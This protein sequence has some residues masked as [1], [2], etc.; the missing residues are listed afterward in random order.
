MKCYTVGLNADYILHFGHCSNA[1]LGKW[2]IEPF[3][4]LAIFWWYQTLLHEVYCHLIAS[5]KGLQQT[6]RDCKYCHHTRR[7]VN[8]MI[9][10]IVSVK[11]IYEYSFKHL[12][13]SNFYQ[14]SFSLHLYQNDTF[15][16][17]V[18]L[19]GVCTHYHEG[20]LSTWLW[21]FLLGILK[22]TNHLEIPLWHN[23]EIV[24]FG[25]SGNSCTLNILICL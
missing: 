24:P 19:S 21:K 10:Y 14:A 23:L 15:L 12:S 1:R 5:V 17:F 13:H 20:P 16:S 6:F 2:V 22:Q 18:P 8:E 11:R 3:E 4:W 25:D 7:E 9:R